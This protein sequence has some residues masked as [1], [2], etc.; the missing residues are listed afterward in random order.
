ML[1]ERR[2]E[3]LILRTLSSGLVQASQESEENRGVLAPYWFGPALSYWS[4]RPVVG[5]TSHQSL[6]GIADTAAFYLA[7]EEDQAIE[8]LRRRKVGYVLAYDARRIMTTSQIILGRKGTAL[9]MGNILEAEPRLAPPCL[10]LAAQLGPF[11]LYRVNALA[12][13]TR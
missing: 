12:H 8:T 11:V 7:D 5:G 13:S 9:S 4:G 10:G 1:Q 3:A 2:S 6:A